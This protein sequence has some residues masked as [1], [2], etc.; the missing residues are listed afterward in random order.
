M[1][2]GIVVPA[3]VPF[4]TQRVELDGRDYVLAGD[5]NQREGKWYLSVRDPADNSLI[6]GPRKIVADW[7][8]LRGCVDARRPPGVLLALDTSEQ[9]SDPGFDELGPDRRV[10]LTYTPASEL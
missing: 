7:N 3:D 4:W 10:A 1:S 5:W 6:H 9:G 2:V 8:L